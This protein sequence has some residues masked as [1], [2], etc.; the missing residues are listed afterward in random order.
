M[1][2]QNGRKDSIR[3]YEETDKIIN[4]LQKHWKL[5][6]RAKVYRKAILLADENLEL[7]TAMR[8]QTKKH[9]ELEE[10]ITYLSSKLDDINIVLNKMIKALAE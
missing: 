3:V 5:D 6:C 7:H 10:S 2:Y 9:A 4:K 8:E 1:A